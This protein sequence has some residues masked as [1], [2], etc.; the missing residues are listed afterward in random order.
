M[1]IL[2]IDDDVNILELIVDAFEV[3][4]PEAIILK[5]KT[6]LEGLRFLKE[7]PNIVLLDLGLPDVSG[8]E[9]VKRIRHTHDIPIII[10]TAR[11]EEANI[12]K[13]LNLGA[14]EYLVKPFGQMELLARIKALT[15]RMIEKEREVFSFRSLSLTPSSNELKY[16]D[17]IIRLSNTEKLI[18][19]LLLKAK[20]QVVTNNE[21]AI[22]LFGPNIPG[23]ENMV[24]AYIYR[25]RQKI[26]ED[27]HKPNII[28]TQSGVG[29]YLSSN[30]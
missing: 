18:L 2:A 13:A 24:K 26:E 20:G 14:D 11:D 4:W 21:L 29:Y 23:S 27:Y 28:L 25:L 15:R 3:A 8:F 9:V 17:N 19:Q 6:G 1:K 5:A 16:K 10:I 22:L 7:E 12:V 30:L